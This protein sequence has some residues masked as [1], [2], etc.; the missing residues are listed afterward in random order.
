MILSPKSVAGVTAIQAAA[1]VLPVV[2]VAWS[3]GVSIASVLAVA[4]ITAVVWEMVFAGVRKRAF[5]AHGLTT[6][7][8]VTLFCPSDIALWQLAFA[9]SLGVCFGELIFGGRG[10]GFVSPAALS[11]SL[12]IVAFPDVALRAPT[13]DVALAVLP[14]LVVLLAIGLISLPV[15]AGT[16]LGVSA[17]LLAAGY[18]VDPLT[19][20]V[21]LSVGAVFLIAD[22]VAASTTTAGRWV[23]GLLAGA[24]VAVFSTDGVLTPEAVVAAAL[25]TSV[26]A[27]LI[28]HGA[29]L[30]HAR[31]RRVRPHV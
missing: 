11:L 23:Y 22:P 15:L 8:I 5:S 13:Q 26:L 31:T 9:M 1:L 28:D 30:L 21:A 10:F 16:A 19:V 24:L 27:P 25:L 12:L 17:I 18:D 6:A 29:V 7:L 3:E 4:A 2:V 20:A 14:G